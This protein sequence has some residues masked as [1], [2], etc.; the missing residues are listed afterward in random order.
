MSDRRRAGGPGATPFAWAAVVV[1]AGL[2]GPWA[3]ACGGSPVAPPGTGIALLVE[4]GPI[5]PVSQVGQ[6]NTE[7]VAGAQVAVADAGGSV[8][9]RVT[10]DSA[11]RADVPL[12]PGSY[13]VTVLTCPGALSL[14]PP[15]PADVTSGSFA[16]LSLECDTGIR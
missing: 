2:A 1:V 10:T 7:P 11:G 3:L 13:R 14:P 15:A 12:V 5:Q 16:S 8:T 9:A 4:R 6:P